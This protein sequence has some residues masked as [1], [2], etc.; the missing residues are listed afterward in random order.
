[1]EQRKKQV[2]ELTD[3]NNALANQNVLAAGDNALIKDQIRHTININKDVISFF[4][5]KKDFGGDREVY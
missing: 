1:M 2:T 4:F 3:K 5:I